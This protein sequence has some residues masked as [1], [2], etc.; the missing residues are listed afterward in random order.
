MYGG[1]GIYDCV[2]SGDIALTFDDG[3]YL[4]TNDLLDKLRVRACF[5]I[6]DMPLT[7]EQ[8]YGAKATFFLTG[9]NIGKGMINDPATPYPAII[10]VNMP[11]AFE[12]L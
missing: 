3:P 12:F 5:W 1:A 4:Y 2:T 6:Q 11:S 10:K 8:S 7:F 9:T